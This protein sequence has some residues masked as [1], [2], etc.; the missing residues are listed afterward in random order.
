MFTKIH[1]IKVRFNL[2][3][4]LLQMRYKLFDYI[5]KIRLKVPAEEELVEEVTLKFRE[6]FFDAFSD[7]IS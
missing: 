7:V 1:N 3:K 2:N 4:N 5:F 6:V